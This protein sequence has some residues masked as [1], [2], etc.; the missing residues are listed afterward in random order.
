MT[1]TMEINVLLNMNL[2]TE[3]IEKLYVEMAKIGSEYLRSEK[4]ISC[5]MIYNNQTGFLEKA[6]SLK[7]IEYAKEKEEYSIINLN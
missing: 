2:S 3:L 7:M 1:K 5:S 6:H 4:L